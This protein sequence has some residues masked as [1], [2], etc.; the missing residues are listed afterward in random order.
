M[1][2]GPL[3]DRG[4][5]APPIS[6]RDKITLTVEGVDG[7]KLRRDL[8]RSGPSPTRGVGTPRFR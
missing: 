1:P 2:F 7:G 6:V 8:G 4:G 5:S 3:S